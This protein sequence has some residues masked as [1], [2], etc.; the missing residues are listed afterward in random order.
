M[1]EISEYWKRQGVTEKREGKTWSSDDGKMHGC[2]NCCNGD[3]CDDPSHYH[4]SSCPFCLGTGQNL[5]S[6]ALNKPKE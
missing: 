2:D 1:A 6:E 3:R 4:R 5:T